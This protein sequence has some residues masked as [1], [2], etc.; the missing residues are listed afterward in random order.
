MGA[1]SSGPRTELLNF[2]LFFWPPEVPK[3]GKRTMR[4][5]VTEAF[6]VNGMIDLKLNLQYILD[7]RYLKHSILNIFQALQVWVMT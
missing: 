1:K 4:R 3:R 7:P 2:N 5:N 6:W